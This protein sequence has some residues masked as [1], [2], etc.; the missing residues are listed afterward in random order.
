MLEHFQP[1]GQMLP[2]ILSSYPRDPCVG[3]LS[4]PRPDP[5]AKLPQSHLRP[6]AIDDGHDGESAVL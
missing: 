2:S 1:L 4:L 3:A 5:W 6:C